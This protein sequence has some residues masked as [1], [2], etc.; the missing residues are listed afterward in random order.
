MKARTK[1]L[2]FILAYILAIPIA[3]SLGILGAFKGPEDFS[4][5]FFLCGFSVSGALI[6]TPFW[7]LYLVLAEGEC[8]KVKEDLRYVWN[9]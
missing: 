1:F 6:L 4:F 9:N 2:L 5:M 3:F 8:K 7:I